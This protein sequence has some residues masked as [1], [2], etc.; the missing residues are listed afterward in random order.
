VSEVTKRIGVADTTFAR[1]DMGAI[2]I[3]ELK[4]TG[5]GFVVD[6]YTVPGVKDLPVA[7]KRLIEDRGCDIVMALGM[8]GGEEIDKVCAHEASTG[9]IQVQLMTDTHIIEVFVHADEARDDKEL[10]WLTDRRTREHAVNAYDLLFR[11]ERLTARAGTGQRQG[12]EDA[13]PAGDGHAG[14]H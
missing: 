5:T 14:G 3:D 7:C 13:G 4:A 1:I 2:A 9:L 8:P 10:A 12:F 6:R 11:P